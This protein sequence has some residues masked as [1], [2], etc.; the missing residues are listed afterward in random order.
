MKRI[1]SRSKRKRAA[2]RV[3]HKPLKCRVRNGALTIEIDIK[4]LAWAYEHQ[5]DNWTGEDDVPAYR[6]VNA[7][8]F[9]KDVA[10]AMNDE[11]EDGSSPLTRFFDDMGTAAAD[12]GSI[13]IEPTDPATRHEYGLDEKP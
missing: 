13:A 5:P 9:A 6:V 1:R 8:E 12:D 7:L 3:R 11:A 4:T 10:S 2:P